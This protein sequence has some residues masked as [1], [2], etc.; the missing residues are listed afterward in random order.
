MFFSETSS[1]KHS[2]PLQNVTNS[3]PILSYFSLR[4]ELSSFLSGFS[5][6]VDVMTWTRFRNYLVKQT[7]DVSQHTGAVIQN[8]GGSFVVS[9]DNLLNNQ[10]PLNDQKESCSR[11]MNDKKITIRNHE[12]KSENI[13]FQTQ[14]L[15]IQSLYYFGQSIS[16]AFIVISLFIAVSIMLLLH[17][18]DQKC[19]TDSICVTGCNRSGHFQY[20]MVILRNRQIKTGYVERIR[21]AC[22]AVTAVPIWAHVARESCT[23][24]RYVCTV[25]AWK[26]VVVT[27]ARDIWERYNWK[28]MYPKM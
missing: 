18:H 9:L 16:S 27:T 13:S 19:H 7:A 22:D 15:N 3:T 28:C 17:W 6:G 2:C 24:S 5:P 14:Y 21:D 20:I 10:T 25:N 12:K 4:V 26:T 23:R 1:H 8:F 11:T